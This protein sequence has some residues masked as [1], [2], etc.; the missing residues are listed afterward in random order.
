M[1]LVS[2]VR[3]RYTGA[4]HAIV[5]STPHLTCPHAHA[6]STASFHPTRTRVLKGRQTR[7]GQAHALCFIPSDPNEGTER[8]VIRAAWSASWS[9]I[10]SDPNEGTERR[11]YCRLRGHIRGFIPSDPN[12]GT[13]R[14]RAGHT[15]PACPR[16]FIPSDP[17]E[18]TES[19]IADHGTAARVRLHSIRP[20]RGY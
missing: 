19:R 4:E 14:C 9:F 5:T 12:E 15:L 3:T 8:L 1:P 7:R 11:L 16:R 6:P 17:N 2:C 18:G 13:E 20:E 10:P